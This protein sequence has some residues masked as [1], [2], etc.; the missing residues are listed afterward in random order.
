[1]GYAYLYGYVP[2][3]IPEQGLKL[4]A[5]HQMKLDP[6]IRFGDA[7]T[8]VLPRGYKNAY[9]PTALA[10]RNDY[11]TKL[12]ADYAIPIY[13]GDI[14]LGGNFFSIKRLILTPHF[15]YTFLGNKGLYSVG[16]EFVIDLHSIL[17][18]EWPCAFGV[19]YSYNGGP[20]FGSLNR[21]FGL[22]RHFVDFVFN[23]SF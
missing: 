19:T 17:T 13:I 6:S 10:T 5:M 3:I 4:T 12:T 16:S 21:E 23:V 8:G 20:S 2:G 7:L 18:L 22:E 15:D 1:M 11:M 14:A 9:L